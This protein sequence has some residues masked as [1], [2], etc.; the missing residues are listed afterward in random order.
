M[1]AIYSPSGHSTYR[2]GY[3][4]FIG[5]DLEKWNLCS[6][7]VPSEWLCKLLI[8]ASKSMWL[9]MNNYFLLKLKSVCFN[10]QI[11]FFFLNNVVFFNFELSLL[12]K[13]AVH[14]VSSSEKIH[15][16]LSS[17]TKIH[18][19]ICLKLFWTVFTCKKTLICEYFSPDWAKTTFS[20][21]KAIL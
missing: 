7:W 8:N 5:T 2:W 18:Q 11:L 10:N 1:L 20:L 14:K 16:L 12:A 4:F 6:E 19:H 15:P 3:F 17:Y 21:K 9:H 13:I